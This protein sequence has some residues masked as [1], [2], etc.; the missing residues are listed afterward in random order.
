MKTKAEIISFLDSKVGKTI[1]DKVNSNLNGQCVTLI[2]SL[3]EFVGA[4]N[5]YAAR[6]NAKDYANSLLNQGIATNGKGQVNVVVNPTMG[7][8]GG[9]TYGHIWVE[10]DGQNWESNGYKALVVTK[11]TR[12]SIQGRQWVNLN[13]WITGGSMSDLDWKVGTNENRIIHSE[14]E[15]WPYVETH[16]G[17]FDEQFDAS[18]GGRPVKEMFYEK[19]DKNGAWRTRREAALKFYDKYKEEVP[20]MEARIK[21]LEEQVKELEKQLAEGG[22]GEYVKVDEL[23]RKI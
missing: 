2:K 12:P 19:W 10:I 1:P 13:K 18:W 4:P 22:S 11:N 5:P 9:V 20:K 16:A 7:V 17:K 3:L 23:Y 21:E 6:G 15:G 8:V 14:M